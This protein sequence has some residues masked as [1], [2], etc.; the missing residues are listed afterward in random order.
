MKKVF[1]S[2]SWADNNCVDKIDNDFSKIGINLTRDQR[3]I[4]YRKSIKEYMKTIRSSEYVLMV[5]S[6][7]YLESINCMYE[8]LEFIKD[9][10][11]KERILPLVKYGTNIFNPLQRLE[12]IKYWEQKKLELK[13]QLQGIDITSVIE[14]YQDLKKIEEIS[15]NIGEFLNVI[16]DMKSLVITESVEKNQI[17]E[18]LSSVGYTIDQISILLS[19]KKFRVIINDRCIDDSYK[20]FINILDHLDGFESLVKDYCFIDTKEVDSIALEIE[21]GFSGDKDTLIALLYEACLQGDI[22]RFSIK[23][24]EEVL[25]D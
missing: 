14:L 21:L 20:N 13:N 2:Y 7:D 22:K 6:K 9:S 3:D 5:I 12:Y 18:I 1:I 17:I 15:K 19:D 8:V 24:F 4:K 10:D 16:S 23:S 11:Y 25:V